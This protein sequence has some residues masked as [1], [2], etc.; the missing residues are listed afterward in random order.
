MWH[1]HETIKFSKIG[2]KD[3]EVLRPQDRSGAALGKKVTLNVGGDR[4]TG[5][6][7]ERPRESSQKLWN[8]TRSHQANFERQHCLA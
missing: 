2:R 4:S 7:S 3:Y 8:L 5:S 1:I 6:Y